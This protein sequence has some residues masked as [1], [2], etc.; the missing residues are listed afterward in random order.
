[1]LF[2][3]PD[4]YLSVPSLIQSYCLVSFLVTERWKGDVPHSLWPIQRYN[5]KL[6]RA[7]LAA[8]PWLWDVWLEA[9]FFSLGTNAGT[10]L[11]LAMRWLAIVKA[12]RHSLFWRLCEPNGATL[13]MQR[14]RRTAWSCTDTENVSQL[15]LSLFFLSVLSGTFRVTHFFFSF[16]F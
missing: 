9:S 6:G 12:L 11:P 3:L 7:G 8:A 5:I 2:K 14:Q 16:F 15:A 1:M 10:P 4:H 13:V